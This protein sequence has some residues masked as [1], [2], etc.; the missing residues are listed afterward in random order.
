MT[1]FRALACTAL[2]IGLAISL[3]S[4]AEPAPAAAKPSL[5]DPASLKAK[6][7]ETFKAK[8]ETTQGDFVVEV[9]R[10]WSP[11]GADRFYNLVKN[12]F[13]DGV[14]VFRVLPGF[15]VQFGI[16]GDPS[17]NAVW[18]RASVMDDP[19]TQ[20]NQRGTVV[21]ATGGPHSRTT[22]V[23]VNLADN[24]R[25]DKSGFSPFGK[26]DEAGMAV[27]EKFYSGYEGAASDEQQS[28]Q[29]KGNAFLES[30]YPKLDAVK[31]ATIVP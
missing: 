30:K 28:I 17:I 23:F 15:V 11:L 22:Q 19:V 4:A 10:S 24:A 31:K 29:S 3:A 13:Y 27:I 14:K 8:F 25:L 6:A 18:Q 2:A 16:N 12:G 26:V 20:S 9:T 1:R 21:F 7:P 5:K